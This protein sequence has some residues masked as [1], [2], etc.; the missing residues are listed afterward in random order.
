MEFEDGEVKE[1][2][3]NVTTERMYAQCEK[4]GNDMLLLDSFIEHRKSQ[5]AMSLQD[6]QITVNGRACKKRSTDG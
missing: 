6:Q 2:T 4:H 3:A 5:L 1:L